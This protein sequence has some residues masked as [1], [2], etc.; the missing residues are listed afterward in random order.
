MLVFSALTSPGVLGSGIGEPS[1]SMAQPWQS[2]MPLPARLVMPKRA[3]VTPR[4]GVG[5][6][7]ERNS[8]LW[9]GDPLSGSYELKKSEAQDSKGEPERQL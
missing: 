5:V 6:T 8:H 2:L 7:Q 3:K 1:I 9:S 4:S